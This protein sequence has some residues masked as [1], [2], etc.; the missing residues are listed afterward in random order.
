MALTIRK[1]GATR[2]VPLV[3]V[4]GDPQKVAR[5]RELLP[6]AVYTSW[7]KIGGDLERAIA[8]P[9]QDPVVHDSLFAAY[10]GKSLTEKLG[11]KAHSV[12]ALIGAPEGF[13]KTL[14]E[15]PVGAEL[16]AGSDEARDLT[17]WF[18]RSRQEL[19]KELESVAA[20][21]EPGPLWIAWPKKASGVASDLS[22]QV[23]RETGL[24]SRLVDYKIC[25]IDATWSG[26]L[27]TRRK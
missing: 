11:V 15:L 17:I 4:G 5:I 24:A 2:H 8:H 25:S 10:S 26:L 6:D 27:F 20:Q 18:A 16:R 21:A 3:F 7:E 19:L 13:E 23:V 22:Q 14:G 9:P 1:G 12:L